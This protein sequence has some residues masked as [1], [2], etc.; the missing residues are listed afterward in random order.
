[1]EHILQ[2]KITRE[3]EMDREDY[4]ENPELNK[5]ISFD[6]V[7]RMVNKLK[8]NKSCGIDSIPNE[9]LKNHDVMA[10][11]YYMFDKCFNYGLVPTAWLK[12]VIIPVPKSST[13]D[14]FVPLNYR[15]IS[16]LSCV[17]KVFSGIINNRVMNYCE[18]LDLYRYAKGF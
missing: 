8:R 2:R 3:A 1:M 10:L 17:C 4:I 18:M 12:A 13:K 14:P 5:S 11:L 9:V 7:E 16:L 15:G 6:E